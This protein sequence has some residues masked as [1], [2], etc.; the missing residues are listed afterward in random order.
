M[1]VIPTALKVT[2]ADVGDFNNGSLVSHETTGNGELLITRKCQSNES[3]HILH[4]TQY[5]LLQ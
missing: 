2:E 5:M 1:I 3:M 4:I